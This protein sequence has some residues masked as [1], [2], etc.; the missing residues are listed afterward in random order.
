[1]KSPK[2][3]WFWLL[4]PA[5]SMVFLFVETAELGLVGIK[6]YVLHANTWTKAPVFYLKD[7]FVTKTAQNIGAGREFIDTLI[8][9]AREENW[10][11]IYWMTNGNNESA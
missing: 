4:D 6:N 2:K 7:L 11:R 5:E 10:H 1:M 8:T 9:K 3:T